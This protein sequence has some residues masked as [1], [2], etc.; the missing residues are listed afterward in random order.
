MRTLLFALCAVA[1]A[2]QAQQDRTS[3]TDKAMTPPDQ[4]TAVTEPGVKDQGNSAA[5]GA[6]GNM[7]R[8]DPS[9][10]KAF[11]NSVGTWRCKGK[12]MLPKEMGG[13]EVDTRSSMTIKRELNGF[14]YT[15][16]WKSEKNK[17]FPAMSGKM[18]WAYDA[19]NKQLTEFSVDSFGDVMRGV[20]DPSDDGKT[21][22]NEEGTMMGKA[23]KTRT[24]VTM[25]GKNG[26]DLAFDAQGDG[27]SW[28]PMGKDSCTK[29]G[30]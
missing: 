4:N 1:F 13:G 26:L 27:G 24:T 14:A 21:V 16:E 18:T 3:K 5:G 17:A 19:G 30:G 15:G 10:T 29:G 20:A 12:M 23:S 9:L 6:Q 8:P 25:K 22:W 11:G 2:A 28:A 7:P